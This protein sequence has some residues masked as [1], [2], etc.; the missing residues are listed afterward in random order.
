MAEARDRNG[1]LSYGPGDGWQW[2]LEGSSQVNVYRGLTLGARLFFEQ[3]RLRFDGAGN[4][5]QS[6]GQPVTSATDDYLGVMATIGYTYQPRL[7]R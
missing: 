2:R 1:F 7:V 3:N 6:S 4:I 5:L